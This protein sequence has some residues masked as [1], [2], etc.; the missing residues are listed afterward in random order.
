M[1]L[2]EEPLAVHVRMTDYLNP[3]IAGAYGICPVDYY[4]AALEVAD[5]SGSRTLWLF[6]DDPAAAMHRLSPLKAA[7]RLVVAPAL[8]DPLQVMSLFALCPSK[9]L[10]NSS[11]SWWAGYLGR[12]GQP[13]V[14]PSPLA[15]SRP[16][17]PAVAPDWLQ[18][19]VAFE[20]P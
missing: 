3:E 5:S 11:F 6:S 19:P 2:T 10:S 9:I 14:A 20:R 7:K 16:N 1:V 13:T 8:T 15:L 12:P 4:A 17:D 18:I